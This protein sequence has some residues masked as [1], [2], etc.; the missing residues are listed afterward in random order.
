[1]IKNQI[2]NDVLKEESSCANCNYFYDCKS[3]KSDVFGFCSTNPDA[4]GYCELW[5]GPIKNYNAC[6]G[7]T[8][9]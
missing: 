1:M 9:L 5:S 3:E 4:L 8:P 6:H 2:Q 7:W